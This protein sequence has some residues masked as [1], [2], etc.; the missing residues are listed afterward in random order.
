MWVVVIFIGKAISEFFGSLLIQY[1]GHAAVTDLRN[2][3][4]ARLIRQPIGFFQHN[5]T[6]RLMSAVISNVERVRSALSEW[7][8]DFFRQSFT[9]IAYGLVLLLV[10]WKMALGALIVF[11]LAY[12]GGTHCIPAGLDSAQ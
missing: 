6:G 11:P 1:V 5:P 4:Y 10:D 3:V 9:F 2:Q 12:S 7:L 8:A